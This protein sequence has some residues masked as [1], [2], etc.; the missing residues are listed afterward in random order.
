MK[1]M[2]QTLSLRARINL[3]L[4]LVLALSLGLLPD[5]RVVLCP[6]ERAAPPVG[7]AE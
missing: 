3:L 2:W 6:D 1:L 7:R 4:A 5:H